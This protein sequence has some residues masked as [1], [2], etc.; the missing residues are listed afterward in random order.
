MK[1]RFAFD[2]RLRSKALHLATAALVAGM[3]L[4][5]AASSASGVVVRLKSGSTISYEPLRA[6]STIRPFDTFFKNL[7]YN[8]GPVMSTNTDYAVYWRPTG[9]PA[10]PAEY[11]SGVNQYFEDLAHDS[12]GHEN[13][14]SV[15]AQYND[16]DGQFATN[17]THFGGALLDTHAYPSNGCFVAAICLTDEQLQAELK[18]FLKEQKLP[19][20]I[21][22]EYFL[23]TPPTV[24]DCAEEGSCSAGTEFPEYCAYHSSI[25]VA[26]GVI[27]YSNDPYVTELEGCDDGN[28]P[29]GKPSDGVIEGGLSHE[30]N[31]SITDPEPP[32]GWA[33]PA[34][35]ATTGLEIGDKCRTFA[36]ATEFGTPLGEV[37]VGGK[38]Y[39]YNQVV[40]GHFYW[41]QQEWSDQGHECRQ[42]LTFSGAE[43][44][45]AFT[46]EPGTSINEIKLNA[47]AS[48][49]PGGVARYS[50][51]FN[52]ESAPSE[53]TGPTMTHKFGT[54]EAAR[55]A[56]TVF[57]SNGT[58][59]GTANTVVPGDEGPTAAF[60]A[61]T[62]APA[63]GVPVE[64]DAAASSDPDGSITAYEWQFGDGSAPGSGS[65]PSHVFTAPGNY[66][67]ALSVTDSSGQVSTVTHEVAVDDGPEPTFT[68][69]GAHGESVLTAEEF[70]KFKGS[71]HDPDGT[72][73]KYSW[74]FGDGSPEL[75]TKEAEHHYA[76]PG[77]YNVTLTVEDSGKIV[78]QTTKEI[79]VIGAPTVTTERP[80]AIGQTSATLNAMINPNGAAPEEC[81][82]EY[83]EKTAEG[84]IQIPCAP[85]PGNGFGEV[86]V[87]ITLHSLP[88]NTHFQYRI[89][90]KNAA[91]PKVAAEM[92][93]STLPKLP[94]VA[95]EETASAIGSTTA[96]LG[97]WI[98]PRGAAVEE[99]K[100]EYGTSVFS[101]ASVP[102]AVLPG[103]G[104]GPVAVSAALSGL[105]PNTTYVFR[106][107]GRSS[108][109][110]G[111]GTTA[112]FKTAP[113]AS[114][115]GKTPP[116][117]SFLAK[118]SANT[119]SGAIS[120]AITVA[121]AGKLSWLATFAN[122]K[123]GAFASRASKCKKGTVK[124]GGRC[125]PATI[126]YARGSVSVGA[127]GTVHVTLKPTASG[128]R[129]LANARKRHK[130]LSVT[131]KLTFQ[132]A[133]GGAPTSSTISM[134]VKLKK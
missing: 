129:A 43:P 119:G 41:Y 1:S 8:G 127:A 103:E 108:G 58:P 35:G 122:G 49:A 19:T 116:N 72:I 84:G 96:T 102:C 99:C 12:G 74:N 51:Q 86:P 91:G 54:G 64:F 25:P 82:I 68:V 104:T 10:Y 130:G 66:T 50:W 56:L 21:T 78:A 46:T 105:S 33:D 13:T 11:Q 77:L 37:E 95:N 114:G 134:T 48:T 92:G 121:N 126:V 28:H 73:E 40:N 89:F 76:K 45:A 75:F 7:D 60:S 101:E 90:A 16:V 42:R 133:L 6:S 31:E 55:V 22:H 62:A 111:E 132:S 57:A 113:A 80:S 128:R 71:A 20:D 32:T 81:W 53:S 23:L 17:T 94:P 59:I 47:S 36:P 14:D 125:R 112:T 67:V 61:L 70:L 106:V 85:S 88:P 30:H 26:G 18:R 120:V 98:N 65:T 15:S 87:A 131:V 63:S 115:G 117:S 3:V 118:A 5:I 124:L 79:R 24:E 83:G 34:T 52:D 4:A 110:T 27:I 38:K 69:S 123:F 9:A 2:R 29:N 93:F 97:A 44:T 109:G 39:K 100:F 107:V